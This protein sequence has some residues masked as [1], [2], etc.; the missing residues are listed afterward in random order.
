MAEFRLRQ[1]GMTVAKVSSSGTGAECE[2]LHYAMQYRSEGAVTI[3]RQV[4][5]K[6]GKGVW[7]K[8]HALFE[9]WPAQESADD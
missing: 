7:W 2:A 8:R 3:E 1:N 6:T 5:N 4:P 9:Q